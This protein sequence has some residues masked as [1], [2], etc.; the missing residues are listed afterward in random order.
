MAERTTERR[1]LDLPNMLSM[2]RVV[3]A[4]IFPFAVHRPAA[5]VVLIGL[6]AVSDFLDGWIARARH[7]AS[8]WGALLDP[9]TDRIF[10]IVAIA[11]Y[12]VV[13]QLSVGECLTMIIRDLATAIGFLVARVVPSLQRVTFRARMSGKITTTVQLLVLLAIPLAPSFVHPLVILVAVLS[14]WAVIDYTLALQR[15]RAT[16]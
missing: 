2:S 6:A 1:L 8:K 15:A 11:T 7:S 14:V 5:Q 10:V 3:L 16:A 12:V 4:A 13:G 9:I